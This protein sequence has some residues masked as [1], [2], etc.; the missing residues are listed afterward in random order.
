MYRTKTAIELFL[1]KTAVGDN[2]CLLW[3]GC[4]VPCG[5]GQLTFAKRQFS[6]HRFF[7]EY[8]RGP[9]PRGLE[10]DHL[11]R[12]RACVNP[13]HLEAVTHKENM[14]RSPIVPHAVNAR[15]V[16]CIRG[17][18]L[19]PAV[20][21]KRECQICCKEMKREHYLKNLQAYK[22]KNRAY[23]IKNSARIIARVGAYKRLRKA[24]GSAVQK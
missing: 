8:V 9:V 4:C 22:A 16:C 10:L 20:S 6:A 12:N 3:T 24:A 21:G 1:E 11:C 5:Y 17:H 13:F 14:M 18:F 2:G 15:K 19:P 23:Y 7:Y